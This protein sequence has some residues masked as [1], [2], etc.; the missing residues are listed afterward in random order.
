M[1][2]Q[3]G[4]E[5]HREPEQE[6]QQRQQP[7]PT[8]ED[9]VSVPASVFRA[10]QEALQQQQQQQQP[11]PE[12]PQHRHHPRQH[13]H[14]S[15]RRS[16]SRTPARAEPAPLP[17]TAMVE[18]E[19][20][21]LKAAEYPHMAALVSSLLR[22]GATAGK[23]HPKN[24]VALL[25]EAAHGM[26]VRLDFNCGSQGRNFSAEFSAAAPS[27]PD[28]GRNPQQ[29]RALER[30]GLP[31]PGS[32]EAAEAFGRASGAG[33][34]KRDARNTAAA[35]MVERLL[36]ELPMLAGVIWKQAVQMY[37]LHPEDWQ[38]E[39]SVDRWPLQ[40]GDEEGGAERQQPASNSDADRH[41]RQH[42][43][44]Q[45]MEDQE[46]ER[47]QKEAARKEER[48]REEQLWLEKANGRP[49]QQLLSRVSSQ[50][51]PGFGSGSGDAGGLEAPL[52]LSQMPF[53]QSHLAALARRQP[54]QPAPTP[55]QLL[56]QYAPAALLEVEYLEGMKDHLRGAP[57]HEAAAVVRTRVQRTEVTRGVASARNKRDAKQMAAADALEKLLS[58]Y[59]GIQHV[60]AGE[61]SGD[62]RRLKRSAPP[63]PRSV[64]D[65]RID[66]SQPLQKRF[67]YGGSVAESNGVQVLAPQQQRWGL[68]YGSES[69]WQQ[70]KQLIAPLPA[71][72]AFLGYKHPELHGQQ[73][74]P[75]QGSQ[76]PGAGP[77]LPGF[78]AAGAQQSQPWQQQQ[79]QHPPAAVAQPGPGAYQH[80]GGYGGSHAP[81]NLH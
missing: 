73:Q 68:G 53:V 79:Q 24:P 36:W 50:N 67:K 12:K 56:N 11:E 25:F 15:R 71:Q 17:T 49:H 64:M 16:P 59:E 66:Y 47:R 51:G 7:P 70:Q 21:G 55:L 48:Q 80:G 45:R 27:R 65:A 43:K 10:M 74:A 19:M 3:D 1:A 29:R 40:E 44:V 34:N 22:Y 69:A 37:P 30:Q 39:G 54:G 42:Q 72:A 35:Q 52:Q 57:T 33:A 26:S 31:A 41:A 76:Q 4:Q 5:Q 77:P 63:R 9:M 14:H 2:E 6:Q 18:A 8:S 23:P 20:M 81:Y 62:R 75:Y 61:E 46:N 60:A 28:S 58:S 78:H 13:H 38:A 32:P